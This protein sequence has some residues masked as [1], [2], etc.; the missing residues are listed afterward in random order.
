MIEYVVQP[1]DTL[2]AIANMFNVP[3]AK[4]EGKNPEIAA[5]QGGSF[6]LI[7][8]GQVVKIP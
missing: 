3:L 7:F 8:P 2:F 6:N 4:L 1:G 5:H